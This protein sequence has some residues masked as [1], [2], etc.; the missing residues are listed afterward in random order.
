ME[1][2][3]DVLNTCGSPHEQYSPGPMATLTLTVW[4]EWSEE[5]KHVVQRRAKYSDTEQFLTNTNNDWISLSVLS[6]LIEERLTVT[7]LHR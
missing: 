5:A 2:T 1:Q 4:P 3:I 6:D 7:H